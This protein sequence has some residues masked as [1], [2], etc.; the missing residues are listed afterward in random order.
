MTQVDAV[1]FWFDLELDDQVRLSTAPDNASTCWKQAL[2]LLHPPV[3]VQEGE[4]LALWVSHDQTR[5]AFAHAPA[6]PDSP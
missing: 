4:K 3:A 6:P 2:Q 5:I 1:V